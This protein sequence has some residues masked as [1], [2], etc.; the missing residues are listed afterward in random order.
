LEVRRQTGAERKAETAGGWSHEFTAKA[1]RTQRKGRKMVDKKMSR[2]MP[3]IFLSQIF[4][5]DCPHPLLLYRK[6]RGAGRR[7]KRMKD[8][9]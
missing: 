9:G 5:S 2:E 7:E 8:E 1:R 3:S 4:L 6:E